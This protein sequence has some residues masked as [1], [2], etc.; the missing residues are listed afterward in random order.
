MSVLC[1]ETFIFV[2]ESC[3]TRKKVVSTHK[4]LPKGWDYVTTHGWGMTDYSKQEERCARCKRK[5]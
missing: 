1:M 4:D 5:K 2:C 3:G